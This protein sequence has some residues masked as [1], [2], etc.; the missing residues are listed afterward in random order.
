VEA[1]FT[2]HTRRSVRSFIEKDIPPNQIAEILTCGL[3]APSSSNSRPWEFVL[4]KDQGIKERIGYLGAR[5]LYE[6]KKRRLRD[7]KTQFENIAKAPLFIVVA[8][9]T[10]KSPIF[11]SH[12]GS[13][14]TQNMLLAA[15]AMGL[16]GVWLGAPLALKK[17]QNEIKKMLGIPKSMEIASIIALGYPERIPSPRQVGNLKDKVHYESW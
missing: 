16:G 12:D 10:R 9:N 15:H 4:V 5:S 11:W 2:I 1:I 6:R 7:S 3:K 17:H 8:C 14:A 13:A